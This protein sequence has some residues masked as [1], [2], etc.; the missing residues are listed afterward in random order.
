[1]RRLTLLAEHKGCSTEFSF[2]CVCFIDRRILFQ[3]KKEGVGNTGL[4]MM[5]QYYPSPNAGVKLWKTPMVG[6]YA[7]CE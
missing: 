1:M 7:V 3:N 2:K 6:E 5:V 4:A